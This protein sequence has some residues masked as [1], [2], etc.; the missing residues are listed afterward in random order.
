M[1][2]VIAAP[3]VLAG[4][5]L[6]VAGAVGINPSLRQQAC[7][8]GDQVTGRSECL[9]YAPEEKYAAFVVA[10]QKAVARDFNDPASAQ[11]RDMYVS[12]NG[13]ESPVLCGE[14]NAK[15]RMGAY[16]GF[17]PFFYMAE[18][19]A[20]LPSVAGSNNDETFTMIRSTYCNAKVQ[21]LPDQIAAK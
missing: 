20:R 16:A 12:H 2:T 8:L 14:V 13:T 10:A 11:W 19:S 5:V 4:F 17:R 6:L 7:N 18:R 21:A 9:R 15:N 1:R 3:L